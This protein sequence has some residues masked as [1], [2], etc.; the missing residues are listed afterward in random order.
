ME[1]G[2]DAG[3]EPAAGAALCLK[4]RVRAVE[5]KAPRRIRQNLDPAV[6][7]D[8]CEAKLVEGGDVLLLFLWA[9][10]LV[11][12]VRKGCSLLVRRRDEDALHAGPGEDLCRGEFR[13]VFQRDALRRNS[14]LLCH[15]GNVLQGPALQDGRH[16]GLSPVDPVKPLQGFLI[17][18]FSL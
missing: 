7:K 4:L 10:T 11:H 6:L 9:D 1:H 18:F 8:R 17:V 13:K 16:R 2:I 5:E 15:I 3:A 12:R 14:R